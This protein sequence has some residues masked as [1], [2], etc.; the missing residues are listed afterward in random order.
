MDL[1]R[2]NRLI[3]PLNLYVQTLEIYPRRG[4]RVIRL[5]INC[6]TKWMI[7]RQ[8]VLHTR[9]ILRLR[10][11]KVINLNHMI[12]PTSYMSYTSATDQSNLKCCWE[13]NER[14]VVASGTHQHRHQTHALLH[15]VMRDSHSTSGGPQE[16]PGQRGDPRPSRTLTTRTKAASPPHWVVGR[17][18]CFPL[19]CWW[20]YWWSCSPY[21][22]R[23][24]KADGTAPSTSLRLMEQLTVLA[25][26]HTTLV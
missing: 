10:R 6:R 21:T 3:R 18:P 15:T 25:L 24:F 12:S 23:W 16:G 22:R 9:S 11:P 7:T 17:G 4:S 8:T 26:M 14:A 13:S 1:L 2:T 5:F 19:P 20:H